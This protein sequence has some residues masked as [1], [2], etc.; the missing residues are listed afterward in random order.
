[1]VATWSALT[2]AAMTSWP[3]PGVSGWAPAGDEQS[4]G[5]TKNKDVIGRYYE[6]KRKKIFSEDNVIVMEI[7]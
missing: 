2:C 3:G 4:S 1:M 7:N 6:C 5:S